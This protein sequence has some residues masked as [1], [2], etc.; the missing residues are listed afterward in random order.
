MALL[1]LLDF[2]LWFYNKKM[3]LELF[4]IVCLSII[5][6]SVLCKDC[7]STFQMSAYISVL[8]ILFLFLKDCN[9]IKLLVAFA[10]SLAIGRIVAIMML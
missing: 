9:R 6:Q 5:I 10:V 1:Q 2:L 3:G 8:P 4:S 7:T